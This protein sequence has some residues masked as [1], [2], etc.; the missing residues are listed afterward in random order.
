MKLKKKII[1]ISSD[2]VFDGVKGNYKE[3]SKRNPINY[4]GKLKY[5]VE[6]YILKNVE[7]YLIIRVSKVFNFNK[8]K[9]HFLSE[10][11]KNIKNKNYKFVYDEFFSPIELNELSSFVLNLIKTDQ[12][13]IFHLSSISKISR[14]II[15]KKVVKYLKLRKKINKIKISSLNLK[16]NRGLNLYLNSNKYDNFFNKNKKT[17]TYYI[18]KFLN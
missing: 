2:A 16:S 9:K 6:N 11:L 17:I 12:T 14:Y 18:S 5:K 4:Y 8:N 3:V 15:A 13:G 10:I 1:F 7:N